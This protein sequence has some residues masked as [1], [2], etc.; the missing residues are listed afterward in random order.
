LI[1]IESDGAKTSLQRQKGPKKK[2]GPEKQ[3]EGKGGGDSNQASEA[4][5]PYLFQKR[6]SYLVQEK[7][8]RSCGPGKL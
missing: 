7:G 3:P 1:S 6:K 8:G 2:R 4:R 5:P